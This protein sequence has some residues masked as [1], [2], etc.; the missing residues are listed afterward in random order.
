MCKGKSWLSEDSDRGNETFY[1]TLDSNLILITP[2]ADSE[3][4]KVSIT[5]TNFRGKIITLK[6]LVYQTLTQNCLF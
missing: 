4:L 5:F 2:E 1:G 6:F 3:I